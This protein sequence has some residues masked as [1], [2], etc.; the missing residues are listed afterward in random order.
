MP[1]VTPK[2]A[3]E[4]DKKVLLRDDAKAPEKPIAVDTHYEPRRMLLNHVSGSRWNVIYYKQVKTSETASEPFN[5]H[6]P[7]PYQQYLK[8]ENFELR[9]SS[10][11]TTSYDETNS[12]QNVTGVAIIPPSIVPDHG[13]HFIADIGDG[14][15]A[16]FHITTITPK[17][18]L[19][20]TAF[21]VEYVLTEYVNYDLLK[22]LESCVVKE[23]YYEKSYADYGANPVLESK[24]H[25][26]YKRIMKWQTSIARH[27]F[28]SFYSSEY[29]TFIV[30][31][32]GKVVYDPF[33]T[34]FITKIWD[35]EWVPEIIQLRVYGRDTARNLNLR[36][37]W[38]TILTMDKISLAKVK[39]RFGLIPRRLL[40]Q[41]SPVFSPI[42]F[43]RLEYI[44]HPIEVVDE[45]QGK[46][47]L[48]NVGDLNTNV[49]NSEFATL[50]ELSFDMVKL[51][52]L[53][54]VHSELQSTL[55]IS[56]AKKYGTFNTYVLS[57]AFYEKNRKEMSKI[58][59]IL[60]DALEELPVE[61]SELLPI[62]E[63][64]INW[65]EL[66]RFY[67]IPLLVALSRTALGDLS[68]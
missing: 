61:A 6:R 41:S 8:I 15:S 58:E 9:V 2:R 12:S 24:E 28:D 62:L 68:Q 33:I 4:Q 60:T 63:D 21:E 29:N 44:Y 56:D 13:D 53:G 25:G 14:R 46:Y 43:S 7:L 39:N 52:G 22:V 59:R 17:S 35:S 57:P 10:P 20:D 18:I 30:P 5:Y 65:G 32:P 27:Y 47:L 1:I 23:G 34:E 38:D 45:K 51:P 31:S 11:L 3:I 40:S 64:C 26:Y 54:F 67:Y 48:P 66:E 36:T 19:R 50:R 49:S 37:I 55:P 42:V 16:L